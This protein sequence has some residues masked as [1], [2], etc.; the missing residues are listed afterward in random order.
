[1]G[2]GVADAMRQTT[3]TQCYKSPPSSAVGR[4]PGGAVAPPRKPPP[5]TFPVSA[6]PGYHYYEMHGIAYI[7]NLATGEKVNLGPVESPSSL[8]TPSGKKERRMANVK[9]ENEMDVVKMESTTS[10]VGI[11]EET[12]K[13]K[14]A[15]N[16]DVV[17]LSQNLPKKSRPVAAARHE[18]IEV[19]QIDDDDDDLEDNDEPPNTCDLPNTCDFTPP[20][21]KKK[22]SRSDESSDGGE[23]VLGSEEQD[24]LLSSDS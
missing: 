16:D 17:D 10:T 19:V 14:A 23:T 22:D 11:V 2:V 24:L 8:V 21:A 3:M 4:M 6:P 20:A 9:M 12:T 18:D 13:R 15:G 7:L 5:T 1:L